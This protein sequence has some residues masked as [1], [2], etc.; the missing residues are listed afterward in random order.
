M[1]LDSQVINPIKIEQLKRLKYTSE[2]ESE[3]M[4]FKLLKEICNSFNLTYNKGYLNE[5]FIQEPQ[6]SKINQYII[7]NFKINLKECNSFKNQIS[8]TW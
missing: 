2:P 8:L 4:Y 7:K 5:W 6:F 1:I 3:E